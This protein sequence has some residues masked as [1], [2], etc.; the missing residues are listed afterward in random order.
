MSAP[1]ILIGH[2]QCLDHR[3]V[4]KM[5]KLR[6]RENK[7]KLTW[8]AV[9]GAQSLRLNVILKQG[10]VETR[11][12]LLALVEYSHVLLCYFLCVTSNQSVGSSEVQPSVK[13]NKNTYCIVSNC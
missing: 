2:G 4:S 10:E 8:K 5:G 1:C 9:L 7:I 6:P 13:W 3:L 12:L 11:V